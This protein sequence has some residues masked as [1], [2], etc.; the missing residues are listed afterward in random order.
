MAK[1]SPSGR[2]R[3]WRLLFPTGIRLDPSATKILAVVF[4]LGLNLSPTPLNFRCILHRS[5][6]FAFSD[7]DSASYSDCLEKI[8]FVVYHAE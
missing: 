3:T 2:T 4:R 1:V 5:I 7:Q 8:E 6:G